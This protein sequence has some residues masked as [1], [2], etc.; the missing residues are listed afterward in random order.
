MYEHLSVCACTCTGRGQQR[1]SD[2]LELE[3]QTVVSEAEAWS[4]ARVERALN[5]QAISPAHQKSYFKKEN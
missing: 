4:I 3:W 5:C 1:V 2:I